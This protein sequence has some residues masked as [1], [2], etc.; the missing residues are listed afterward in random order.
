VVAGA[1]HRLGWPQARRAAA[2]APGGWEDKLLTLKLRAAGGQLGKPIELPSL[3][4]LGAENGRCACR[5]AQAAAGLLGARLAPG[6]S[7]R[8]PPSQRRQRPPVLTP[9]RSAS[10]E[11]SGSPATAASPPRLYYHDCWPQSQSPPVGE[12]ATV[13]R[14]QWPAPL[15]CGT[16]LTTVAGCDGTFN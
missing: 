15:N 11:P 7:N 2:I 1:H 3:L 6:W 10:R 9:A 8:R 12:R 14:S 16:V 13:R 5:H 4:R